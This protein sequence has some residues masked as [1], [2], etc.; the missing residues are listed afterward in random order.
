MYL[1]N[2]K[3][4]FLIDESLTAETQ[5]RSCWSQALHHKESRPTATQ[6]D[7]GLMYSVHITVYIQ[8]PT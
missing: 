7:K 2:I 1:Y 5:W 8:K 3:Y 4:W 6:S